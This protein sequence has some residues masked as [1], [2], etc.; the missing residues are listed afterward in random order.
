MGILQ[1]RQ[2]KDIRGAHELHSSP[3]RHLHV[4]VAAMGEGVGESS[5]LKSA[6]TDN[7]GFQEASISANMSLR[8]SHSQ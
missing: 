1:E 8:S 3:K 6:W 2:G 4:S 5:V 7:V